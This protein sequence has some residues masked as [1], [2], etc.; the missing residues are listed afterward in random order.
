V[1]TPGLQSSFYKI[2]DP[3]IHSRCRN[4]P[5]APAGLPHAEEGATWPQRISGDGPGTSR[6]AKS[7]V[8]WPDP[9]LG[10]PLIGR[11]LPCTLATLA[12]RSL[13]SGLSHCVHISSLNIYSFPEHCTP[14]AIC[15]YSIASNPGQASSYFLSLKL[16]V[17]CFHAAFGAEPCLGTPYLLQASWLLIEACSE[18]S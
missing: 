17:V 6:P 9:R 7:R 2:T 16:P 15:K 18:G 5:E 3:R 14:T 13:P 4:I 11:P 12:H 1:H 10:S 8:A